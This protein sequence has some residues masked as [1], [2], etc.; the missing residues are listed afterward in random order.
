MIRNLEKLLLRLRQYNL[1]LNVDKSLF[2]C[3]QCNY[4]GYQIS[5]RGVEPG[6][7]KL[8]AIEKVKPPTTIK[9]VRAFLGLANYFRF[10][11]PG[12]SRRAGPLSYL[13]SK[14][15]GFKEG[16]MPQAAKDAFEDLKKALQSKPIVSFPD[17]KKKFK[18][19]TRGYPAIF[20]Q[21]HVKLTTKK[22]IRE[23]S[24]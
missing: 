7:A 23:V 17:P 6:V 4:L 21:F 9:E 1:K 11:I 5:G 10:M 13:T 16:E 20:C 3:T 14:E 19:T 24:S 8:K 15:A 22:K 12:F 18:L 2:A